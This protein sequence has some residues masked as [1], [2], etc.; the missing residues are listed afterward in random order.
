MERLSTFFHWLGTPFRALARGLIVLVN[1][2]RQQMRALFS[3]AMIGGIVSLSFQNIGLI[4]MVRGLL[5]DAAPG[6]LFGAMALNQQWWNNVIMAGFAAILGL[7]VFGA[8]YFRAK[9]DQKEIEFGKGGRP[10]E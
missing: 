4:V 7:V 9:V 8:D 10:E 3:L 2:T 1:L 5:R 6:S